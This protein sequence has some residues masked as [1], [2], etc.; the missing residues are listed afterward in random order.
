MLAIMC[1]ANWFVWLGPLKLYWFGVV[2]Y[3]VLLEGYQT[4]CVGS[5]SFAKGEQALLKL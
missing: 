2:Y 3:L 5:F 4:I 1:T